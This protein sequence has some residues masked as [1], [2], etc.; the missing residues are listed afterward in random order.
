MAKLNINKVA[1]EQTLTA[2]AAQN[3]VTPSQMASYIF[4]YFYESK[5][6]M[7]IS[8]KIHRHSVCIQHLAEAL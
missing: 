7:R 2:M 4:T 8:E 5:R 6:K 1:V 3:G